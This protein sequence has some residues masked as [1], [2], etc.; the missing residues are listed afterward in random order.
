MAVRIAFLFTFTLIRK[1][2][3]EMTFI[4][5]NFTFWISRFADRAESLYAYSQASRSNYLGYLSRKELFRIQTNIN[6]IQYC[7]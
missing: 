4:I 3:P 5:G 2:V 7:V 1:I 6:L